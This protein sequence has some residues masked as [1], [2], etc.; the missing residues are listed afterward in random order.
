M[1]IQG[2]VEILVSFM[3]SLVARKVATVDS[4]DSMFTQNFQ[5]LTIRSIAFNYSLKSVTK[6]L[7]CDRLKLSMNTI[8]LMVRTKK[9][10]SSE[11]SR[12][13]P[14]HASIILYSHRLKAATSLHLGL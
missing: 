11:A 7:F 2:K 6:W 9:M 5:N 8:N 12:S 10:K 1:N 14:G 3:T 13:L 4:M